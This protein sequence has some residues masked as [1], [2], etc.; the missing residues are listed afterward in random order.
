VRPPT[1]IDQGRLLAGRHPSAGLAEDAAGVVRRLAD[2]GVTLFLDL[3]RA[4]ELEPYDEH[5]QP[6]ARQLRFPVRDLSVPEATALELILDTIDAEIDAGGVVYLHCW[7]GC[8]RTGVVAGCWLVRHGLDPE[9]ALA[10]IAQ[11]RGQG[12]PQTIEQRR[13]VLEW[14]EGR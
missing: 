9:E 3:T 8:G 6:P 11:A 5:L 4:G 13:S 1:W 10:R 7:A 2:E 12:C 14:R